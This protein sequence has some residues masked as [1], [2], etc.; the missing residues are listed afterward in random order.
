MTQTMESPVTTYQ[1]YLNA[2]SFRL[3][4]SAETGKYIF[5]PRVAEP[6]T[7]CTDLTWEEVEGKGT[8]YSYTFFHSRPPKP[9]Y[10]VCL[11]DLDEGV[12]L[13]SR[14]E[15][16]EP[17]TLKIGMRVK[18]RVLQTDEDAVIVFDPLVSEEDAA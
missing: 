4:K 18:A 5:F 6:L 1:N 10:N 9:P 11:I 12:R 3:Q 16:V 2:G 8:V 14:V 17:G 15:G 7:G 13:M